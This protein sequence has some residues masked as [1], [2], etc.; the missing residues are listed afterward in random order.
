MIMQEISDVTMAQVF[1]CPNC[2]AELPGEA[3]FCMFCGK[4]IEQQVKHCVY[5]GSEVDPSAMYCMN[6]GKPQSVPPQ[7]PQTDESENFVQRL[8]QM[9]P[10][11]TM[12]RYGQ[13]FTKNE[14]G[15]LERQE[16]GDTFVDAASFFNVKLREQMNRRENQEDI[17]EASQQDQGYPSSSP[18]QMPPQPQGDFQNPPYRMPPQP[19]RNFQSPPNQTPQQRDNY[20][21]TATAPIDEDEDTNVDPLSFLT[22]KNKKKKSKKEKKVGNDYTT[23]NS[24]PIEPNE[25]TRF[26]KTANQDGYYNDQEPLDADTFYDTKKK[27]DWVPMLLVIGGI[28]L[29]TVILLK[30]SKMM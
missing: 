8:S 29:L 19:Q 1:H 30:F 10:G 24:D 13:E 6:C 3:K 20:V 15:M 18:D 17:D 28:I 9:H 11:D 27:I 26:Q 21:N 22:A 23:E 16:D 2:G 14:D 4:T 5:C 12:M 25:F 7:Q